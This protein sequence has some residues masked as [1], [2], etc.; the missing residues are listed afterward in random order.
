[1]TVLSSAFATQTWVPSEETPSGSLPTAMVWTTAPVE[2][3]SSVTVCS[4]AFV[5]QTWVPSEETPTGSLP[6]VMVWTTAPVEASSSVTVPLPEFATQTWVPSEET[7]RGTLPTVIVWTT[8]LADAVGA[9]ATRQTA[10]ATAAAAA[11]TPA[12][13]NLRN[14]IVALRPCQQSAR[15]GTR[16]YGSQEHTTTWHYVPP[17]QPTGPGKREKSVG[18]PR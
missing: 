12:S 2:A 14:V 1:M 9:P 6:T 16:P 13:Q 7:P 17:P 4:P 18:C 3:S 15:L 10:A 11:S 5:T 8:A